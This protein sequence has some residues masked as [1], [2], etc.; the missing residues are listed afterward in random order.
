MNYLKRII[1]LFGLAPAAKRIRA[2]ILDRLADRRL[3]RNLSVF[4]KLSNPFGVRAPASRDV[5]EFE[6]KRAIATRNERFIQQVQEETGYL[7]DDAFIKKLGRLSKSGLNYGISE[8]SFDLGYLLYGLVRNYCSEHDDGYVNVVEVGTSH[9]FSSTVI[10]RAL[11]DS[12]VHGKVITIDM[13]PTKEPIYW[14]T[15]SD[16]SGRKTIREVLTDFQDL[17]DKYVI[18]V[19][20]SSDYVLKTV[21]VPRV[22]IAFVD[23]DHK[24]RSVRHDIGN[25]MPFQAPGDLLIADDYTHVCPGVQRVVDEMIAEGYYK[26]CGLYDTH[27]EHGVIIGVHVLERTIRNPEK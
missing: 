15:I 11:A 26:S 3:R 4:K 18:Y 14:N 1:T 12:H 13:L 2:A 20:G 25:L 10:A 8:P 23:G 6:I 5:Y 22:H 19:R 27:G 17:I 9:G 7:A 21:Y 24:E 16:L